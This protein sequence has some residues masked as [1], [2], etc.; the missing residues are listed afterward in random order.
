MV[1]I[2]L[3][4]K[5]LSGGACSLYPV[6]PSILNNWQLDIL[7]L[8]ASQAYITLAYAPASLYFNWSYE[9]RIA[10]WIRQP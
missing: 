3:S 7:L 1:R 10:D 5:L 8:S 2:K 6:L 4:S 9:Y